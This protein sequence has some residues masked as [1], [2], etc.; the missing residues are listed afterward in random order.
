MMSERGL[1]GNSWAYPWATL[2][3]RGP[4]EHAATQLFS[5]GS[6]LNTLC[7]RRD[8]AKGEA[9]RAKAIHQLGILDL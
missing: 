1:M 4:S 2:G 9:N 7:Q 5:R 3:G 8:D 6:Q